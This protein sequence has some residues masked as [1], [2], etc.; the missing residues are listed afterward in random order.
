MKTESTSRLSFLN[1]RVLTGFA[2]YAAS[3]VL[4][5]GPVS[6]AAAGDN[7]AAEL[8]PSAPAQA[9]G[10]WRVTGDLATAREG[11]EATLLPNGQVLVAAGQD[12]DSAE[13]YDPATGAWTATG[14]MATARWAHTATLLPNGKVLVAGGQG[15]T[16]VLGS[17]E[18]YKSA[19]EALDTE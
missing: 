8:S 4:A 12:T 1:P 13:Q 10:R 2:L 19:R 16:G 6:S 17:A 7:A 18:L 9:L 3:L 14:S 5:F 11:H 15:F